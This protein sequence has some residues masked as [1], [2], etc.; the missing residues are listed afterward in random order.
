MELISWSV[1]SLI[2]YK[3][4]SFPELSLNDQEFTRIRIPSTVI[5][6]KEI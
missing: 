4:F 3:F 6:R 1:M 2:L 5:N